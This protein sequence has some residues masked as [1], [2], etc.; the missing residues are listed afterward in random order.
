MQDQPERAIGILA[1]MKQ[2]NMR[3]NVRT[4]EL[5]FQLFGNVNAPY[6]EGN[7]FS[8]AEVKKRIEILETDMIR[9]GVQHSFVSLEILV[10][11][12]C[13]TFFINNFFLTRKYS[14]LD[15]RI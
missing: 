4:F 7:M 5:L 15:S 13:R 8:R 11:S 3:P 9:N 2:L 10:C 1:K 12:L 14:V 6:E